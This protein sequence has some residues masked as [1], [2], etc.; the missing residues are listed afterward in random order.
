MD[1]QEMHDYQGPRPVENEQGI[2]WCMD[3]VCG[4]DALTDEQWKELKSRIGTLLV[5]KDDER[6]DAV[7]N[8]RREI[9]RY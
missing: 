8:E 5:L 6:E 3:A 4:S 2:R 1:P 7:E 9:G